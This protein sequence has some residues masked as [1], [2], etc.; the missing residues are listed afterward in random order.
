M[1]RPAIRPAL[2]HLAGPGR[3]PGRADVDALGREP[4]LPHDLAGG[5]LRRDDDGIGARRVRSRQSRIVAPNFRRHL[6]GMLQKVQVVNGDDL[7]RASS[8]DQHR[9][10]AVHDITIAGERLDRRPFQP[11][12]QPQQQANWNV[13]IDDVGRLA[14]QMQEPEPAGLSMSW[15][16]TR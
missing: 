10:L 6:F 9:A 2:A 8:G 15:K 7:G 1:R 3:R 4:E 16:T 13:A 14:F 11:V 5:V 12:P